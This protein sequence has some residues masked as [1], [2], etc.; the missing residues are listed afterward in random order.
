MTQLR[1]A[2]GLAVLLALCGERAALAGPAG[3]SWPVGGVS[4]AIGQGGNPVATCEI[5]QGTSSL[6]TG[7]NSF[8]ALPEVDYFPP[9]YPLDPEFIFFG[10]AH[11]NFSTATSG[12][13][14]F[15]YYNATVALGQKLPPPPPITFNA[16]SAE[17][18]GPA[19]LAL[20]FT[21]TIDVCNVGLLGTYHHF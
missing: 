2:Y 6:T 7:P 3:K 19:T 5:G 20:S 18:G 11:L 4:A 16:Y 12:T 13:V 17:P 8:I 9:N 15:D 21:L 14:T 10:S 1:Y